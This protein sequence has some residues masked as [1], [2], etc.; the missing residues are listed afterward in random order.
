L[1]NVGS[2]VPAFGCGIGTS[3]K[4]S[5]LPVRHAICAKLD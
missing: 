2:M 4:E 5:R 3:Q 1:I